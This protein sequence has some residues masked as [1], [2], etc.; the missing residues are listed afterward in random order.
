VERPVLPGRRDDRLPTAG[1]ACLRER[2]LGDRP[3]ELARVLAG[4]HDMEGEILEHPDA[5]AVP[6]GDRAVG[7]P[8]DLVLD[9]LRGTGEPVAMEGPVD[10]RR[11][12]PA[13]DRV[14]P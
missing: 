9:R 4:S 5:N 6:G 11:H 12:P 14:L 7:T 10:D 13:G 2:H 3:V 8:V 1:F